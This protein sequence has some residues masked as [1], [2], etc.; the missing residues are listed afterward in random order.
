MSGEFDYLLKPIRPDAPKDL[1]RRNDLDDVIERGQARAK[2][3]PPGEPPR[4]PRVTV[5]IEINQG[6]TMKPPRAGVWGFAALL[7][8]IVMF[9]IL[10]LIF[11]SHGHA[12]GVQWNSYKQGFLT[13]HDGSD[14]SHAQSY[15]QG[16]TTYTDITLPDGATRHCQSYKA[17]WRTI[18]ECNE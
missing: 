4:P 16:F 12:Q 11:S 7:W 13:M 15:T 1:V 3:R 9:I 6:L 18:T 5:S 2:P 14:G 17:D 10:L 8:A